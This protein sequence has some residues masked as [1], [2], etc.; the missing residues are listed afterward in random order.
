MIQ[1]PKKNPR[2]GDAVVPRSTSKEVQDTEDIKE[3]VGIC[4]LGQGWNFACRLPGKGC[5]HYGKVLHCTSRQTEAATVSKRRGKLSKGILFLQDNAA[6]HK[7]AITHQKFADLHFEVLKHPAY[8]PDLAPLDYYLFPNLKGRKFSS[9]EE[10]T[11]APDGWFGAQPKEFFLYRLKKLEQRS[12][13]YVQLRGE[14]VEEI[15]FFNT[16][17]CCFLYKAKDLSAP[18]HTFLI[19]LGPLRL[20][21]H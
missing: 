1:K 18:P 6:P 4:D 10:A 15:H 13:K 19:D 3:G 9:N 8:S 21:L 7:V 17:A 14:Y 20:I 2:N 11:L 5:N 12:H 16:V